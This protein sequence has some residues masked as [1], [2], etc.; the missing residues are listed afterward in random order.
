VDYEGAERRGLR[1]DNPVQGAQT[2]A[3]QHRERR[4]SNDEFARLGAA[5][6]T[7]TDIWVRRSPRRGSWHSRVGD[8]VKRWDYAGRT[9]TQIGA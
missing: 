9:L 1:V 8:Q 7:A 3:P 4:L 5:L 6:R 2:F